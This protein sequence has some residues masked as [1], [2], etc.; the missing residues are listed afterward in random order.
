MS[1][2]SILSANKAVT[3]KNVDLE[4]RKALLTSGSDEP[5]DH[6]LDD[7]E[8]KPGWSSRKIAL[9]AMALI[10]LLI[11]GIFARMVLYGFPG[12]RRQAASSSILRSNGTHEFKPTVLIVSIDGLRYVPLC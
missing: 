12:R 5:D 2:S 1:S 8:D 10:M 3:L 6:S 4:E 11:T 9:T 7:V